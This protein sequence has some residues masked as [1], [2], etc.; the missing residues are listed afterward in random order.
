MRCT[1]PLI[2]VLSLACV[3]SP[4]F[5]AGP[6]TECRY[7]HVVDP[8]QN[9]L[10]VFNRGEA[11][12]RHNIPL[13]DGFAGSFDA[14]GVDF[15]TVPGKRAN[16]SFVT[17]GPFLRVID[18]RLD[19]PWQTID[20]ELDMD[21]PGLYMTKIEAGQAVDVD[22]DTVYPLYVTGRL[23]H[24]G[25]T[26]PVVVV[27][28]Q[29]ALLADNVN[30]TQ[31]LIAT[32]PICIGGSNCRGTG[33][34][35]AVGAAQTAGDLR[36]QAYVSVMDI[37]PDGIRVHRFYRLDWGTD[38]TFSVGLDPWND[39][40]VPYDGLGH[41]STGLDFD[42]SGQRPF[43]LFKT[44]GVVN[45]L[46]DGTATC[47][48]VG[49]ATDI[50]VWGPGTDGPSSR[51]HFVTSLADGGD[52]LLAFPEGEC[53]D[54]DGDDL[55]IPV[56]DFPRALAIE[57]SDEGQFWVYTANKDHGVSAAR[58][59]IDADGSLTLEQTLDIPSGGCPSDVTFRD[60]DV[61][62]CDAFRDDPDQDPGGPDPPPDPCPPG[63]SDPAC[64]EP[65]PP[66]GCQ[67]Q[68]PGRRF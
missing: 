20:V 31:A 7:I 43:G 29:E 61:L 58:I 6:P 54:G 39:E 45:D 42:E 57:S 41:R 16:F 5:A 12:N 1:R 30:P 4:L 24:P 66:E 33:L 36:Q 53:P 11:T 32:V 52:I 37:P 22:G 50:E 38:G 67:I 34:D 2:L 48:I 3:A 46:L 60:S 55:E 13:S 28:D 27:F 10:L 23:V 64:I 63:S 65:C 47:P 8:C 21:I 9:D 40:G 44:L 18:Q 68:V 17:Q 62:S 25:Y 49:D 19:V 26:E 15:T 59:R 51:V 14:N 35:I 56:G